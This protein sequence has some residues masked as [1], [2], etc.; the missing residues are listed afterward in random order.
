MQVTIQVT[1]DLGKI[2][3]H[4]TF[5]FEIPPW[6]AIWRFSSILFW[7]D[8]PP[9]LGPQQFIL[10]YDVG[11]HANLYLHLPQAPSASREGSPYILRL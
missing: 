5:R 4:S 3:K 9:C 10:L 6:L 8:V 11:P 2:W 1:S 7:S